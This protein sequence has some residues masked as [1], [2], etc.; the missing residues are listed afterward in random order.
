M[1]ALERVDKETTAEARDGTA[2]VG[3]GEARAAA[4][5][6]LL[7]VMIE[8]IGVD[9]AVVTRQGTSCIDYLVCFGRGLVLIRGIYTGRWGASRQS[10]QMTRDP[11]VRSVSRSGILVNIARQD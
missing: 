3:L 6:G 1:V 7:E 11:G 5:L 4:V 2:A 9:G 10:T 8:G